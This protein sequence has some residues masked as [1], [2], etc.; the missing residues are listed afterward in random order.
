M[1]LTSLYSCQKKVDNEFI[2]IETADGQ[3]IPPSLRIEA[4]GLTN[5]FT[6]KS[7][8]AWRIA[9]SGDDI[10]WLGIHPNFGQGNGTF[11]LVIET[12]NTLFE[13]EA[14]LTIIIN[15]QEYDAFPIKQKSNT[16]D[17]SPSPIASLLDVLFKADGTAEDISSHNHPISTL[18]GLAMTTVYDNTYQRYMARF[19][20][21]PGTSGISTGFYRVD[22][23]SN[24]I[25]KSALE[26]GHTLEAVF[27]LDIDA[28]LP[29]A[30]F[31]MLSSHQSGG[32]GL[33][34]GNSSNN[35][36]IIFLLHVGG[37]YVWANSGVVPERGKPYHVV[38][39]WDREQG[40]SQIYVNG[41][42]KASVSTSGNFKFPTAGA[43]WLA[44]GADPSNATTA[45]TGWKGDV[46]IAR[47][48]DRAL[49]SL[50]VEKLWESV[51]NFNSSPYGINISGV[52]LSSKKVLPQSDYVIK[53]T[54]F[55]TGDKIKLVS[56][57]DQME[58]LCDGVATSNSFAFK[59]PINLKTGQYRFYVIR[60]N[61]A[62]DLG[63]AQ[64]TVVAE[65]PNAPKVI[66]HRGHWKTG[67]PQN[68]IA[69]LVRAQELD[70]YGSECDLWITTD[71]VVILNH[72]P[73][74]NGIR[75]EDVTY[76]Q[77]KDITL[78]NGE[79]LPVLQDY[80]IQ[81][82]KDPSV[83]LI[84]E[85]K[86]HRNSTNGI[87]NTI[88]ATEAMVNMV[89]EANMVEQVEYIVWRT[90]VCAK[91]LELQPSA[92]IAY[93]NGDLPPQQLHGMGFNGINY[94]LSVI[95][96][97]V[98][99]IAE[100]QSLGMTVNVWTVNAENDINEMI[101]NGVNYISTDDPVLATRLINNR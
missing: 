81:G 33:M 44:I 72:D 73:T 66:A 19:N 99:W 40:K 24:P 34:V 17:S 2:V 41:E 97:N 59:L 90:D 100:A 89:K 87:S 28:P 75:I 32:T 5:T 65:L 57:S 13:R 93:L 64:L 45:Q 58:Y 39:A 54:G 16:P 88:R 76:N 55:T 95:R 42:L 77:I 8:G 74:I 14:L 53:G 67:A 83:K 86:N 38:G 78:P 56:T 60:N 7:N 11:N 27:M 18:G 62:L 84:L 22:Y 31:K 26:T 48:Y 36:A 25:F 12:N 10:S 43:D 63:F 51:E 3:N 50:D 35:N 94:N 20:H 96:N 92:S 98:N 49:S 9:I 85:L 70:V 71:G 15:G 82:K 79:K 1:I 52:S 30:E 68:S 47:V 101:D 23:S 4:E 91:I 61:R 21:T 6:V 37:N 69:S 29:D 46:L 80:L